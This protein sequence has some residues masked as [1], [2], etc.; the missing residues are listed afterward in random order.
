VPHEN[1]PLTEPWWTELRIFLQVAHARSFHKAAKQLGLTHPTVSRAVGRLEQNIGAQLV[2]EATP[3]GVK[4][5]EAG[6]RLSSE[7]AAVDAELAE[8][9]RSISEK[10]EKVQTT[11]PENVLAALDQWIARQPEPHPTRSDAVKTAVL[12]WLTSL[13]LLKHHDAPEGANGR[14]VPG[15]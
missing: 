2:A 15:L 8:A 3:R 13:G 4:L 5:T 1:H 12:D 7:I 11:L 6:A 14:E 9:L 10:G